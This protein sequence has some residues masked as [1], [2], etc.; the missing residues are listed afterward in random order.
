MSKSKSDDIKESLVKKFFVD[1]KPK[2]MMKVPKTKL[3]AP[4]G[5]PPPVKQVKAEDLSKPI[6]PK[7]QWKPPQPINP[8]PFEKPKESKAS[9]SKPK[10]KEKFVS[11]Y[12]H[13]TDENES[14]L[15]F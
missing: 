6:E 15:F 10:E 14:F 13:I 9:Q 5:L 1:D 7:K 8:S 3:V 11:K 4:V 2:D 12:A